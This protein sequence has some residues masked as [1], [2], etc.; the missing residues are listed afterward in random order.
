MLSP[1]LRYSEPD[2]ISQ[3]LLLCPHIT[4]IQY[5]GQN[6]CISQQQK[7]AAAVS[8]LEGTQI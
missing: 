4:L 6:M 3:R 8:S 2:A 7:F 5:Y 1:D